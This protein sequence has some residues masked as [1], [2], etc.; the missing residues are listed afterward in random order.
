MRD[1]GQRQR[2]ELLL[3]KRQIT[4]QLS[5][6]S[7]VHQVQHQ[8]QLV[9]KV[10]LVELV[11]VS[12]VGQ[13][14]INYLQQ[15]FETLLVSLLLL[16]LLVPQH[17]QVAELLKLMEALQLITRSQFLVRIQSE[18]LL[19]AWYIQKLLRKMQRLKKLLPLGTHTCLSNVQRSFQKRV[20]P[21]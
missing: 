16:L 3:T 19:T 21:R 1:C 9:L 10:K 8:L 5:L 12:L 11:T 6:T 13:L 14:I 4:S 18:L 20:M 2:A 7:K 17:F 15:I